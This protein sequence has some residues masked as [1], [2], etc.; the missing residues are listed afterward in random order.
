MALVS[1][2]E[3]AQE[4]SFLVLVAKNS[5]EQLNKIFSSAINHLF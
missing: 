2:K 1:L 5:G 3:V 4:L